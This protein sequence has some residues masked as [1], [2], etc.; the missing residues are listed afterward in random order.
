[1]EKWGK[2]ATV[3]YKR[4]RSP[5][6]CTE[7][8]NVE[9]KGESSSAD[10]DICSINFNPGCRKSSFSSNT[11]EETFTLDA[12]LDAIG[13]GWFQWKMLLLTGFSWVAD[14]MEMMILSILGP[15]LH[16]EWRLPSYQVAFITSVVFIG[17]AFSSSLWGNWSDKYGRKK[18]LTICMCWTLYY[19]LL[20]AF[21]PGY[22]W[23][24]VL[25]G[26]VGF[27]I[28]GA[29][30]SV[31]LYSELLPSKARGISVTLISAFWSLGCV[32]EVLLALWIMPALGW[33]W[34]LILSAA[35][36]AIFICFCFCLPESPR[37]D[38]LN[39][40][41][42]KAMA[43]LQYMAQE[44]GKA[45]PRGTMVCNIHN[46]HGRLRDLFT[47]QY[48]KTTLLLW[49]LWFS[50]AF[51]Y[52]GI[53]LLTTEMFQAGDSCGATQEAKVEP[54]CSLECKLL[55]SVDYKAFLWTTLAE[56]PGLIVILGAVDCLGRKKTMALSF[57]MFF[58]SILTLYACIGRVALTLFIFIA[59]AF[60][61]GGFQVVFVY[62]PEVFPTETR[63]L[64]MGFSS[65]F[66]KLGA[67]ITPFVAQVLL[68]QSVYLTLAVYCG[69]SLLAGIVSL[70]LPIETIGRALQES[71]QEGI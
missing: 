63:A 13:F 49:F 67:L 11:T 68:R 53:I 19:S 32:F 5:N 6:H 25:R 56:F 66:S 17:M 31:T 44:N 2:S 42:A 3:T 8:N 16:C 26:L 9:P 29:P 50:Y 33:R 15:Q 24:L 58:L 20:S 38:L 48:Y 23:L 62:T 52:Y 45:L 18:V 14:A 4:W 64:A 36:L 37:F 70:L 65:A 61:S 46:K 43:T 30:Q 54:S 7:G 41:R 71:K 60:I 12:A 51:I 34:L 47:P 10:K 35:P 27:G 40:N 21:A 22:G 39:G 1:M 59:R 57:F 69:C 28:G 55:T